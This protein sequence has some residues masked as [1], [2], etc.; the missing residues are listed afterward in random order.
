M[1]LY[2]TIDIG[3]TGTKAALVAGSGSVLIKEYFEYP[4]HSP[5]SGWAEQDCERWWQAVVTCCGAIYIKCPEMMK[6]VL[7]V[8]ICGQMHT[9]VYLDTEGKS[10][11]PAIT[12]MDQRA[13]GIVQTL[14]ADEETRNFIFSNT[15]NVATTTYTAPQVKWV[16][17]Q[18]PEMSYRT[19][20]VLVAKD[21]IKFRLTGEMRTD[22]SEAAG[23]L[24]FN[25]EERRWSDEM[26]FL[27]GMDRKMF[28][29]AAPSAVI[30]GKVTAEASGVT[31]IPEGVPVANGSSDN[32]AAALGA[33]MTR[34]G[35][36]TLIVGTAGVISCCSEKP[37][38][39]PDHRT[40]CW[41]YCLEDRWAVLGITQTAGESLNWF[42]NTFDGGV[43][44]GNDDIFQQYNEK[45]RNV[46]DGSDG[47]IFLPYLNGERTPY[48]DPAARGV[49]FGISLFSAK[50][51]FIKA[52]MEGVS[53][54]LRNCIDAVES[55]GI[56]VEELRAVGGGIKSPMWL[57]VL[58]K[59]TGKRLYTLENPDSGLLGSM[60]ILKKALNPGLDM[61][62][63]AENI[64]KLSP[65]ESAGDEENR[66]RYDK[67][68]RLFLDIYS[69]LK[70]L[71]H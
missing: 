62:L 70:S 54:A 71:F 63:E 12:W 14:N 29:D 23:T 20:H 51:N 27:F 11:R 33:G 3:T 49:F 67:Q 65:H 31:G 24:L 7:G 66:K 58:S 1:E 42:R 2:L 25:V 44:D 34:N 46:P 9:H 28:P 5:R 48:W 56:N 41:N 45:V 22:Y 19:K 69:N 50:E 37:L 4:I 36:A 40:L 60:L 52:I 68:Y 26:F 30:M 59:I 6:Q 39:D 35:Q 17:T 21:Y 47:L 61:T 55:L 8:G 38:P 18:E 53:F 64:V 13:A 15:A 43:K 16:F 10:L 32:S 57:D